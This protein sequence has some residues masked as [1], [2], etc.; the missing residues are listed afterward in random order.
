MVSTSNAINRSGLVSALALALGGAS[1]SRMPEPDLA[2]PSAC[3][4]DEVSDVYLVSNVHGSP[5]AKDDNGFI[6][7]ISPTDGTRTA[8]ISGDHSDVTLHAP[9]GMAVVGEVLWVADID[10]LRRFDRSSGA[11]LDSINIAGATL[12]SDVTAAPDGTIY[13]SD[14]GLDGDLQPTG[15]DAIW[16]INREGVATALIKTPELGQPMGL[17]ARAGGVYVVSWRDGAF[18]E[19]DYRGV[20]TDL[21][22]APQNK[23][24]GLV[25]VANANSGSGKQKFAQPSWY[26]S[27]WAGNAIYRFGMTGGVAAMPMRLEEAADLGYDSR[28][29]CLVIPLSGSNRIRVE[30]L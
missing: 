21:G 12:L 19:I 26:A 25:R 28:R 20:R 14:A 17:V 3:Y 23:L 18:Y 7:K 16:R 6:L 4:Y 13:C 27:S 2:M 15:T 24:Q 29:N 8:W 9:R 1:C 5:T 30:Q 10:M 22:V 11:Q